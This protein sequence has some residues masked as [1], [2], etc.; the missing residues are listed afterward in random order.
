MWQAASALEEH[1]VEKN[2][3]NKC[4]LRSI[5]GDAQAAALGNL[6]DA[7]WIFVIKWAH[8]IILPARRHMER[9]G[10]AESDQCPSCLDAIE[11]AAFSQERNP[12]SWNLIPAGR[13]VV[14]FRSWRG[15]DLPVTF[16]LGGCSWVV[17]LEFTVNNVTSKNSSCCL[18]QMHERSFKGFQTDIPSFCFHFGMWS[19]VLE[20]DSCWL[21]CSFFPPGTWFGFARDFG[22][23]WLFLDS[24]STTLL[25]K[26][27]LFI[28]L[29][30]HNSK[31]F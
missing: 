23:W 22:T 27:L 15:L 26:T 4:P 1:L 18:I 6:N 25:P 8:L 20:F 29:L 31:G 2:G 10:K 30:K 9:T 12:K 16:P 19:E 7:H 24:R 17:V 5:Q 14:S 28:Q 3:W 21:E 11:T 13:N